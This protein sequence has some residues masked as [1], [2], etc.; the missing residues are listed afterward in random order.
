MVKTRL[1]LAVGLVAALSGAAG[2]LDIAKEALRDGLWQI[3]RMHAAN[4]GSEEARLIILESYA[5]EGRWE[6]IESELEKG[7][8]ITNAPAYGYYKAVIDGRFSDAVA[9][10]KN[11]GSEAGLA[12]AKMLEADLAL[13]LS[14]MSGARA[15][16]KEVL[17]MTNVSERAYAVASIN[18]NEIAA[19]KNAYSRTLAP[20]LRRRI[21]LRLGIALLSDKDT[22]KDGELRIR[23]IIADGS[24][25]DDDAR[26]AGVA[27]AAAYLREGMWKEASKAYANAIE[28]WIVVAKWADVQEGR[29]EAFYRLGRR[30]EALAAFQRAEELAGDDVVKAR[31]LLREGDILSDLGRGAEAL[32]KYRV[33]LEKYPETE[34]AVKLKRLMEL[35]EREMKGRDLYKSYLFDEAREIFREVA[36]D[37]PSREARMAYLE[38]LCLYGLGRDEAALKLVRALSEQCP[39]LSVRGDAMLWRAKYA[40][41]CCEWKE[42][43]EAF[44]KFAEM[45]AGEEASS[46]LLWAARAAFAGN[47]YTLANQL[48]TNLADNFATSSA[49]VPALLIQAEVLIEQARYDEA[50]LVLDRVVSN[51]SSER[52]MRLKARLL[53][54]DALFAMGTDNPVRYEGALEAYRAIVNG[55]E[56]EPGTSLVVAFKIGRVLE[57]LKRQVEANDQYYSRVVLAYR[58]GRRRNVDFGD[59]GRAAFVRAAF[60]LSEE[61]ESHGQHHQAIGVLRLVSE[62]DV[63]SSDEA[64][65]RIQKISKKGLF[66]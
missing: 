44:R 18:L 15:L 2:E 39:D 56:L 37:D 25:D 12:E 14:D 40:Y 46:A 43:S 22:L 5:N 6:D 9:H 34:T 7:G 10:L 20:A 52:T 49:L 57:R 28:S 35:R 41:N 64:A 65:K 30:E 54:A 11:C 62:S 27:I 24:P 29:G 1:V 23:Q 16:W 51:A 48:V 45:R 58:D 31:V 47:D 19:L 63:P 21:G 8:S 33:I 53:K 50:V 3:A 61:F 32:A 4:D 13:K 42:S 17:A 26:E 55:E 59:E 38:V 66:L 60:R 36:E